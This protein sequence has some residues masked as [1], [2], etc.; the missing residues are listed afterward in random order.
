VCHWRKLLRDNRALLTPSRLSWE[1]TLSGERVERRV[2]AI[3]AAD[4][5]GYSRLLAADEEETLGA[6]RI[7]R[8]PIR[9]NW[10]QG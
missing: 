6:R 1:G 5:G 8:D 4:V 9:M 3:F 10:P 2:D 7:K